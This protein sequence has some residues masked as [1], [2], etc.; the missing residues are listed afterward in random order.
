MWV[1][2]DGRTNT[3]ALRDPSYVLSDLAFDTW[4]ELIEN[5]PQAELELM[6]S[7]R[8]D[9]VLAQYPHSPDPD[10]T[11]VG[12]APPAELVDADLSTPVQLTQVLDAVD[13]RWYLDVV[14]ALRDLLRFPERV[15]YQ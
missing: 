5:V 9:A 3:V 8:F 13:P 1:T 15:E 2:Q 14:D 6:L 11:F 7:E 12:V 4:N 10:D